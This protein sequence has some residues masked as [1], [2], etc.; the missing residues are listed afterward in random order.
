ML[1]KILTISLPALIIA[2]S[3]TAVIAS[4]K[5]PAADF[6][7]SVIYLD[8]SYAVVDNKNTA[9]SQ[10]KTSKA[11]PNYP[12]ANFSPTVIYL[13]EN[14]VTSSSSSS[15]EKRETSKADPKYPAANFSPTVTYLD[16]NVS[17]NFSSSAEKSEKKK[18]Q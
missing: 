10:R 6:S 7:P 17:S 2:T 15:T 13:D 1:K 18:S 11:D 3:S 5:Y 14:S 8:E 12:A 4:E 16:K 9:S